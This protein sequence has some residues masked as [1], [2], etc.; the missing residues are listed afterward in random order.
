MNEI[1]SYLVKHG[2][3]VLFLA[4]FARQLCL[5]V[6]GALF[7]LAAGAMAGA[8][9]LS[10]PIVIGLS[11]IACVL[12]DLTWF[13]AGRFFGDKIVHFMRGFTGTSHRGQ[14]VNTAFEKYGA[15]SLVFAKFVLGLDAIV[16]PLTGMLGTSHA[17]FVILDLIGSTLWVCAYAGLGYALNP[18]LERVALV[19]ER[20]GASMGIGVFFLGLL[21]FVAHRFFSWRRFLRE[22]RF[23]RITPQ[24]LKRRLDAG[25]TIVLIDLHGC[26]YHTAERKG[27]A[28]AI[29]INPHRLEQYRNFPIP[30]EWSQRDVVL[31]CACPNESTSARVALGLHRHGITHVRPLEGGLQAWKDLGFP[32]A[33]SVPTINMNQLSRLSA[34][35]LDGTA[36]LSS[37]SLSSALE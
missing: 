3:Y 7:L 12:A 26:P 25:E 6:P 20:F 21:A 30:P 1:V 13:E 18:Q 4:V 27:I 8:G 16:P 36:P 24:E 9:Q 19:I 10:L 34:M 33:S 22:L 23:A 31:Y 32:L 11:V 5:P 29:R 17:R 35:P 2:Y 14:Q 28:G 37:P 15:N